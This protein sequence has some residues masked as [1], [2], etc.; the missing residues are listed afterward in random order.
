MSPLLPSQLTP[1]LT[2]SSLPQIFLFHPIAES[3]GMTTWQ[4]PFPTWQTMLPQLAFFFIFEDM[5]HY[6]CVCN[7]PSSTSWSM[8]IFRIL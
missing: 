1:L 2:V 7:M 6:F 3:F 5:F 4:V 8:L